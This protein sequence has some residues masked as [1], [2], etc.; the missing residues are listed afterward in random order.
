MPISFRTHPATQASRRLLAYF[1][2]P[3]RFIRTSKTISAVGSGSREVCSA[4]GVS[5]TSRYTSAAPS[6]IR[7]VKPTPSKVVAISSISPIQRRARLGMEGIRPHKTSEMLV[8]LILNSSMSSPSRPSTF[9]ATNNSVHNAVIPFVEAAYTIFR[10]EAWPILG[11]MRLIFSPEW[12]S[13]SR[14]AVSVRSSRCACS[15]CQLLVE[16]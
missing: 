16:P 12:A 15:S 2:A 3:S 8:P 7:D 5:L 4:S 1:I 11:T 6:N 10:P 13:D 9:A 14:A